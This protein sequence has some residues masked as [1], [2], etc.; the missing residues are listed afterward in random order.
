MRP[1][2]PAEGMEMLQAS[3]GASPV[4][5]A[6]R[7]GA[8]LW[9]VPGSC[10]HEAQHPWTGSQAASIIAEHALVSRSN[11]QPR[12]PWLEPLGPFISACAFHTHFKCKCFLE[13]FI[14][15]HQ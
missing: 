12:V 13:G 1:E 6:T 11:S 9:G 5:V 7:L 2:W 8:R 14:V 4:D 10:S 3:R 15:S